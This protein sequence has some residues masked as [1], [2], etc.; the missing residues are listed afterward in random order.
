MSNFEIHHSTREI[1]RPITSVQRLPWR[2]LSPFNITGVK[3]SLSQETR[4]KFI[5][6]TQSVA[7]C[8]SNAIHFN[9]LKVEIRGRTNLSRKDY[10][11][12]TLSTSKRSLRRRWGLLPWL[13]QRVLGERKVRQKDQKN[14][15]PL[16]WFQTLFM[17]L[18][19]IRTSLIIL[20]F[21]CPLFETW[22]SHG[23]VVF[24][25]L[26]V[27]GLTTYYI[28]GRLFEGLFKREST[29]LWLKGSNPGFLR[30][31]T[32]SKFILESSYIGEGYNLSMQCA[33]AKFLLYILGTPRT[34]EQALW[35]RNV[36]IIITNR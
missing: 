5:N 1:N 28:Q 35:F 10:T 24:R 33:I 31:L 20:L 34:W 17:S 22:D 6:S 27:T 18:V 21:V 2:K 23:T 9:N 26:E 15:F 8:K 7:T 29:G 30:S 16:R 32:A 19:R 12:R 14:A 25:H 3:Y 36:T 13:N 11:Q 4:R